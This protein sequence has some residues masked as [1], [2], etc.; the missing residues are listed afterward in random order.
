MIQIQIADGESG[1]VH[2]RVNGT[3]EKIKA[4]SDVCEA[5]E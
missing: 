2:V 4:F 1:C 5:Q 3:P